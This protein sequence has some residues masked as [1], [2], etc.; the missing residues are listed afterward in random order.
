MKKANTARLHLVHDGRGKL[1]APLASALHTARLQLKSAQ[2]MSK[3]ISGEAMMNMLLSLRENEALVFQHTRSACATPALTSYNFA[4]QTQ[5]VRADHAVFSQ[6]IATDL[7]L[8]CPTLYF[9]IANESDTEKSTPFTHAWRINA[10]PIIA[11]PR[12]NRANYAASEA[13]KQIELPF[14]ENFPNRALTCLEPSADM[15]LSDCRVSLRFGAAQLDEDSCESLHKTRQQLDA[16][17]W[18]AFHPDTPYR[19]PFSI[20]SALAEKG[21]TLLHAWLKQPARGYAFD[22][23]VESNATLGDAELQAIA[24]NIFGDRPTRIQACDRSILQVPPTFGFADSL[25]PG[26]GLAGGMF[27]DLTRL[28]AYGIAEHFPLPAKRPPASGG[29]QIGQTVCGRTSSV[30]A[31][32]DQ[33]RCTHMGIFGA[34]GSGKSTFLLR[35]LEQDLANPKKSGIGLIDPH[36]L[37]FHDV[38]KL[39][40][41][42]RVKDVVIVDV[43]DPHYI[44]A[45]NP[46][47]GMAE[48]AQ[49]ASFIT[50]EIVALI[51]VLFEN[52][53]SKGPVTR[54][55][56]KNA[57]LL[58]AYMPGRASTFLDAARLLE[59]KDFRDY[60]L[61]K[62]EDRKICTYWRDFTASNG[63]HGF[64]NWLPYLIPRL[65]PF[66]DSPLMRRMINA[67]AS[68]VD[69]D[70]FVREGKIVLFNLSTA[71]LGSVEGRIFGNL[72]LNR[73]F[74]AAMRRV[75]A[76]G[77]AQ[78][79]FHLIVDEAATMV[80]D[81]TMRLFAEAR[82]Y[83]L[84]ITT[85]TQS[86]EQ[87]KNNAGESSIG[88]ALLANTATKVFFRLGPKDAARLEPYAAP[89]FSA[90]ELTRLPV[91][92]A[93]MSMS[94]QGQILPAFIC[95][96]D[97]PIVDSAIH[98]APAE[99]IAHS[100]RKHAQPLPEALAALAATHDLAI[101][102]LR[103]GNDVPLDVPATLPQS[104]VV[105]VSSKN[106]SSA[107]HAS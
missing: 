6:R 36:G 75:P 65:A 63:E 71:N 78:R 86:V 55:H 85:A 7:A 31:L 24:R 9:E 90:S 13:T 45:I 57:I 62:C 66:C 3:S 38:L 95:K 23:I 107:P 49:Y 5:S 2:A 51:D 88:Q 4:V 27:P 79:P 74:Y 67:P 32:P 64:Q 102:S 76:W 101:A 58:S 48:D 73:I 104:P 11:T 56:I 87:L 10:A 97:R 37:L 68:T 98:A 83:S 34:S 19:Q 12:P 89:E 77:V 46:L 33:D 84:S 39:I 96:V 41:K 14:P 72:I 8:A 105:A 99:V 21:A 18:V 28:Q 20:D 43:T 42:S 16:K 82:K 91:F 93:A 81:S 50:N 59:D 92:H 106:K 47:Q 35:L 60:L 103:T 25:K 80:S 100:R 29:A 40:P 53:E 22:C 1:F 70:R 61:S 30:V 44:A 69:L 15:V 17:N 54:S 94:D 52:A 26:Q